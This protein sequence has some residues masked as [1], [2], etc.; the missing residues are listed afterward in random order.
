MVRRVEV[1]S[2][3]QTFVDQFFR[4]AVPSGHDGFVV[5]REVG[6][7]STTVSCSYDGA[8]CVCF[9]SEDGLEGNTVHITFA[10]FTSIVDI[11]RSHDV[12]RLG[13]VYEDSNVL[14]GESY[15]IKLVCDGVESLAWLGQPRECGD[16]KFVAV[17]N[18]LDHIIA[19]LKPGLWDRLVRRIWWRR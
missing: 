14:D 12:Q 7:W 11:L 10:Q 4:F 19:R 16:E 1:S 17:A 3:G 13:A 5:K 2:L 6:S 18:A 8:S 15:F 9:Y